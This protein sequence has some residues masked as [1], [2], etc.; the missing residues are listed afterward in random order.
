MSEPYDMYA[1][2]KRS[3]RNTLDSFEQGHA[4][5]ED[6]VDFLAIAAIEYHNV[7]L[8]RLI[9]ELRHAQEEGIA[10]AKKE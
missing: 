7:M 5:K 8:R 2:M 6:T 10:S 9:D 3:M 4:T 1:H